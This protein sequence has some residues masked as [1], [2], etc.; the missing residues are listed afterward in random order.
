MKNFRLNRL[1]NARSGH[2]FDV[3]IDHGFF[4]EPSFLAGI[5]NLGAAVQTLVQAAPDA[6]QLTVGQAPLLQKI[7]GREKPSLVLRT[8]VANVYG[9]ELP[10]YLFSKMIENPVEQ[11]LRLDATCVVVNLFSIPGEP[12]VTS[13]CI[14]NILRIKPEADRWSMPLM[15]EPLV[16]RPN[17]EAGGYMVDG[18]ETKI[19]PLVRQAVEL[20]ADIIKADPTDDVS[21]YHRIIE[22]AGRIPVL[23]RGGGKASE[24]EILQR[25]YELMQQGA[26][27][28]V[29]GRNVIQHA[30]PAAITRALMSLVHDGASP[31]EAAKFLETS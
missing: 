12:E 21:I 1:F 18:D 16:F 29:Y 15:I 6:I 7:A 22:T 11:A 23:V 31:A 26:K 5:E 25:T 17:S 30:N 13:Q 19:V 2:C 20:G 4:G 9:R 28:I 24:A 8:D 10:L 27:G 14:D 3:A